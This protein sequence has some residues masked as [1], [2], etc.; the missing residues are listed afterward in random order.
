M[1]EI[2]AFFALVGGTIVLND[3]TCVAAGLGVAQGKIPLWLAI[4]GCAT[5]TFVGDVM[6]IAAGRIFGWA[7]FDRVFKLWKSDQRALAGWK[8]WISHHS[9]KAAFVACFLPGIRTPMQW[10]LGVVCERPIRLFFPLVFAAVLYASVTV[11]LAWS[12]A[13]WSTNLVSQTGWGT[14]PWILA[15]GVVIW[16]IIRSIGW[17]LT[18]AARSSEGRFVSIADV[19]GMNDL[20]DRSQLHA[21]DASHQAKQ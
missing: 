2:A 1:P 3:A 14:G 18:R 15:V 10:L 9:G 4:A 21:N 19:S 6:I 7:L 13:T 11:S 16:L 20:N 17:I 8:D 12:A 5:G